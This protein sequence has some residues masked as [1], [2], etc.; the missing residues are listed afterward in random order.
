[1]FN[2]NMNVTIPVFFG[3]KLY[4]IEISKRLYNM[5]EKQ[6]EVFNNEWLL[7]HAIIH[8]LYVK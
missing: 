4:V 7:K 6:P 2:A 1:M 3:N 5:H 8:L